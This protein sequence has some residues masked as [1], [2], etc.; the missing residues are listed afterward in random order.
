[1]EAGAA[2]NWFNH[3]DLC[4]QLLRRHVQLQNQLRIIFQSHLY[5][6]QIAITYLVFDINVSEKND[7]L[8]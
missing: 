4:P 8:L 3:D 2:W 5:K 6:M 7:I 1:V